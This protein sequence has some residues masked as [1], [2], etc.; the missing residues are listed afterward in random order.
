MPD[1]RKP[2]HKRPSDAKILITGL[3]RNGEACVA[4]DVEQLLAATRG[5]RETHV[6]I[7]E[8]DSTDRTASTLAGL[9]T[10]FN[11]LRY[12]SLG[13]LAATHP[14]RSERM[15]RCRNV[16]VDEL[17]NNPLY[18][19]IDYIA[20]ADLDGMNNLLQAKAIESCWDVK[21]PWSVLTANQDS[22][23]YDI[24]ALRHPD[25]CPD[26]CLRQ[27]AKLE[28]L[29]GHKTAR[30]IAVYA[31]QIH[32]PPQTKPIP[33]QSAFGGL[34]IYTRQA[35]LAGGYAAVDASGSEICEHV[36]HHLSM[37]KAGHQIFINPKLINT[38]RTIHTKNKRASKVIRN[39][40]KDHFKIRKSS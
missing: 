19:G 24:W 25:W 10:R 1:K 40:I 3:I 12:I 37:L 22:H 6:L 15:A 34:A 17:R 23:Y 39:A 36:P 26:D 7:I 27:L 9:A 31:R 5:F 35:M 13:Q 33:V 4:R 21:E 38:G 20:V 28:P 32:I 11:R 18:A 16:Y 29:F 14:M 30:D 8:S 2:A